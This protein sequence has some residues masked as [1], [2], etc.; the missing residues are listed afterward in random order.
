MKTPAPKSK[1]ASA[2]LGIAIV[3]VPIA[4]VLLSA[5]M[6]H[7]F[8]WLMWLASL[9]IAGV[10][11]V[12]VFFIRKAVI[13]LLAGLI[14][15]ALFR[16]FYE[17]N[18]PSYER[19]QLAAQA[20]QEKINDEQRVAR[21]AA[22]RAEQDAQQQDAQAKALQEKL[23]KERKRNKAFEEAQQAELW[24]RREVA[25]FVA[26]FDCPALEGIDLCPNMTTWD[27]DGGLHLRVGFTMMSGNIHRTARCYLRP[28]HLGQAAAYG[29]ATD[30]SSFNCTLYND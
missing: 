20:Q 9:I 19:V 8:A 13:V 24:T 28:K 27:E 22:Q 29:T 3:L 15:A 17:A 14:F 7:G 25:P 12:A 26:R 23:T 6:F 11:L 21:K 2:L 5:R 30:Y 1:T 10:A 16:H 4:V 18:M